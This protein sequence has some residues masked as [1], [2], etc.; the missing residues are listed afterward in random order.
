MSVMR[1]NC[2]RAAISG[3]RA[4]DE[5]LCARRG[6]ARGDLVRDRRVGRT[7]RRCRCRLCGRIVRARRSQ[8]RVLL[9]NAYAHGA[10]LLAA[11]WCVTGA[12][13]ELIGGVDVGYADELFAR[14]ELRIAC[15]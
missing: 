7:D 2:S 6:A 9:M 13:V 3:S 4:A 12:S 8:D 15:C 5:R 14:G 11:T 10:A 1:T